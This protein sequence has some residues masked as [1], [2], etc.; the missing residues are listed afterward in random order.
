MK[1]SR[2]T[3]LPKLLQQILRIVGDSTRSRQAP[4]DF[5]LVVRDGEFVERTHRAGDKQ[6]DV[7]RPDQHHIST[8]QTEARVNNRVAGIEWQLVNLDVLVFVAGGRDTD[9]KAARIVCRLPDHVDDSGRRTC[10]QHYVS[11][12]DGL[13]QSFSSLDQNTARL[14]ARA[15]GRC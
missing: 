9:V 1:Y 15:L 10:K 14:Q 12:R 6:H 3:A 2:G 8:F 4:D 13:S 11:G 5:S 7:A